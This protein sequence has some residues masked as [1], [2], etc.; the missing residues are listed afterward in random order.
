MFQLAKVLPIARQFLTALQI[1]H[2]TTCIYGN[3]I[4][5]FGN[6]RPGRFEPFFCFAK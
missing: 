1:F 2:Y 5:T 3:Q 4:I 6:E